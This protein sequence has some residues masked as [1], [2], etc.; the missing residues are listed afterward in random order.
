MEARTLNKYERRDRENSEHNR[1]G[2]LCAGGHSR[3]TQN[4]KTVAEAHDA[5]ERGLQ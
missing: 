2:H 5:S 3:E 1:V 4:V